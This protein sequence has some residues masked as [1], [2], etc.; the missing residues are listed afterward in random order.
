MDKYIFSTFYDMT[1]LSAYLLHKSC[2]GKMTHKKFHEILV[3]ALIVQLDKVNIMVN[4]ISRG[5]PNSSRAKW[6]D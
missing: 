2:G 5:R 3:W 6:V 1:I 4:G